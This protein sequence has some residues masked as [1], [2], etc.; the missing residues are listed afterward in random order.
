MTE[1]NQNDIG[2]ELWRP[3]SKRIENSNI[4]KY[5]N[6][7][8]D[9]FNVESDYDSLYQW[10]VESS[11]EFWSELW[12][13]SEVVHS[14]S[15]DTVLENPNAMPGAKWFS[16]A[17]LNFAENLLRFRDQHLAIV[18]EGERPTVRIYF[19]NRHYHEITNTQQEVEAKAFNVTF[20]LVDCTPGNSAVAYNVPGA[21]SAMR[22]G[23]K[24][25]KTTSSME[26]KTSKRLSPA[27]RLS[28]DHGEAGTG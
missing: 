28:P 24:E 16:G 21:A 5:I 19:R 2:E 9:K 11:E 17:R 23:T 26:K 8:D 10:S 1:Y 3:D 20:S 6:N 14:R 4:T 15:W 13:Q 27:K 7:L 22:A 18:F 25:R 12:R